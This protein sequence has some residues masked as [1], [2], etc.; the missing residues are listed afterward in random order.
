MGIETGEQTP[1]KE[2]LQRLGLR[3]GSE[4]APASAAALGNLESAVGG[5]QRAQ[6]GLDHP[7][8]SRDLAHAVA[9]AGKEMG[10]EVQQSHG[11]WRARPRPCPPC[12]AIGATDAASISRGPSTQLAFFDPN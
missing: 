6:A 5:Y 2:P 11:D 3:V 9:T 10:E 8:P 4:D 1:E 12:L 7:Q